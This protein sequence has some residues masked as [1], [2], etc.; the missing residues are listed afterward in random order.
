MIPNKPACV[1]LLLTD[2]NVLESEYHKRL[3]AYQEMENYST[4]VVGVGAQASV[5][6]SVKPVPENLSLSAKK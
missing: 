4:V 5:P 1:Q 2:S 3:E 6:P